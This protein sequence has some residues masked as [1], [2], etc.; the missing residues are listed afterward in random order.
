MDENRTVCWIGF[1]L[2]SSLI[3]LLAG[4]KLS[5]VSKSMDV[6]LEEGNPMQSFRGKSIM[7]LDIGNVEW[8]K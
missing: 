5:D 7:R 6:Q 1:L 4:A 2:A 3:R 8:E